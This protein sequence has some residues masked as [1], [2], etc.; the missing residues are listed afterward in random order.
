MF[1]M[2]S[3]IIWDPGGAVPHRPQGSFHAVPVPHPAD[4]RPHCQPESS[5]VAGWCSPPLCC[6]A[7]GGDRGMLQLGD[8]SAV[9]CRLGWAVVSHR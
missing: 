6:R 5:T 4:A 7:R 1:L 2:L 3:L 8:G 9:G